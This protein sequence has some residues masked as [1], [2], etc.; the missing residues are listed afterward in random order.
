MDLSRGCLFLAADGD[1]ESKRAMVKISRGSVVRNGRI[2]VATV[3]AVGGSVGA[4]APSLTSTR[5]V[6]SPSGKAVTYGAPTDTS[7]LTEVDASR[8]RARVVVYQSSRCDV[9]PVTV[10]QRYEETLEG[11]KVVHRKPLNKRQEVGEARGQ[12]PCDQSYARNVEVMLESE[13]DRF[14][15]GM[16]DEHGAV[17]ADLA[18]VFQV[19]SYDELPASAKILLRPL[20]AKPTIEVGTMSLKQLN[21]QQ[22]RVSELL[23]KLEAILAKGETGA[24]AEEI[25]RSYE[26][27]AQL[28]EIAGNDPRVEGISAR[29][30][31][32]LTGRKK[33]EARERMERNLEALSAAKETLK[34]MGDAAVPIYV[35]AAVN[36]GTLDRR[37][38]EWSSLRL[39]RALRGAPAVCQAGFSFGAVPTYGW[40]ADARLAA[41]YVN[42]GR[43]PGYA[44]TVGAACQRF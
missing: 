44:A 14:A 26:I 21:K 8:D 13:G 27:Y 17:A 31:E 9:I 7:Y 12:V 34:V 23:A 42:Y 37:A 43:G 4:C 22:E 1:C 5:V 2:L 36:S 3:L 40:P 18:K 38:L 11:E 20:Q 15:L 6:D 33:E 32:L 41:Q 19:G 35:Q 28:Q 30:W 16:T 25:T 29:F 24:S 10:L 39:I